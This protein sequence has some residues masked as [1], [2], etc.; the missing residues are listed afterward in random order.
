MERI[1]GN[2]VMYEKCCSGWMKPDD[3]PESTKCKNFDPKVGGAIAT[4]PPPTVAAAE[5]PSTTPPPPAAQADP[6]A[7]GTFDIGA[8]DTVVEFEAPDL[9]GEQES[10]D[11]YMPP[12]LEEV[13]AATEQPAAP[14]PVTPPPATAQTPAPTE[15]ISPP[16]QP[17]QPAKR[18]R[19]KAAA[20]EQ[21]PAPPA[22]A[23]MQTP[24]PAAPVQFSTAQTPAVI[25]DVQAALGSGQVN[26]QLLRFALQG[27]LQEII[28]C[29]ADLSRIK[30]GLTAVLAS[31]R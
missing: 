1:C 27:M 29:E 23:P 3:T 20:A 16:A 8:A 14:P 15:Q 30:G 4:T 21:P 2:C 18:G 10:G 11:V 12:I 9:D 5:Q 19:S 24:P 6:S 7:D 25:S 13:P 26:E 22:Q 28:R 31:L 17:A